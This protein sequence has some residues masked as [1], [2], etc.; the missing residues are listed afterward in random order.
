[1][2]LKPTG[3]SAGETSTTTNTVASTEE[4]EG[5]NDD[6]FRDN[7]AV[8]N[9]D[10]GAAS[11]S[12]SVPKKMNWAAMVVIR[13]SRYRKGK[14]GQLCNYDRCRCQRKDSSKE[15]V[16]TSD[17]AGAAKPPNCLHQFSVHPPEQPPFSLMQ[18]PQYIPYAPGGVPAPM[19][20]PPGAGGV[21]YHPQQHA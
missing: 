20:Y 7:E 19:M 8:E 3:I 15:S 14:C 10:K 16:E 21:G 2:V 1:L 4:I 18:S 5:G 9:S 17:V 6:S 11:G 13:Y 12:G